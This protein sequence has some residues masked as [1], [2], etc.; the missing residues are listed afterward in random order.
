MI[1]CP[2]PGCEYTCKSLPALKKHY[3]RHHPP[4][5]L[6]CNRRCTSWFGLV[7]HSKNYIDDGHALMYW[8]GSEPGGSKGNR[9][10]RG[11]WLKERGRDVA[12]EDDKPIYRQKG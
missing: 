12:L 9:S 7:C 1:P 10:E 4:V 11:T 8:L 6:V 3:R 2:Y 5:C